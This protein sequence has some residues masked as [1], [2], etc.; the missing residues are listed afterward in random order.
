MR[1]CIVTGGLVEEEDQPTS[2]AVNTGFPSVSLLSFDC[3]QLR[4]LEESW[5]TE[6]DIILHTDIF[7]PILF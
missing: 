2:D 5:K 1:E 7:E 4:E 6:T 3:Q